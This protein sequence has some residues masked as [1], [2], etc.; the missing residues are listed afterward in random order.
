MVVVVGGEREEERE[1]ER[2]DGVALDAV[3]LVLGAPT[4]N[5][6]HWD[7]LTLLQRTTLNGFLI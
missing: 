4:L 7:T 5:Y 3:V 2:K 1:R 6:K